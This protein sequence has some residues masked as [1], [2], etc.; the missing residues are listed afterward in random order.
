[1]YSDKKGVTTLVETLVQKGLRHVVLSPGSRNAPLSLSFYHHPDM[2]CLVIPDE[3]SAAYFAL[4]MAQ[5]YRKPVA[6]VC[7]SGTAALNYAPAIAEAYYQKIPLLI[8]TA[9][10]PVAWIDQ[11]DGQTI[12]QRDVFMNYCKNNF[13]VSGDG[14][15]QED[16]WFTRRI[17][18]R[19]Y[20]E[21]MVNGIGP[22]HI[23]IPLSEP[24]YN[25]SEKLP[26]I[27]A[28]NTILPHSRM[29]ENDLQQLAERWNSSSKKII[30]SG[31]HFPD[32]KLNEILKQ[33]SYD[34]SLAILTETTS[35][36]QHENFIPC[37]DRVITSIDETE[38]KI[39]Q[40][41]I[42]VTFG[43]PV[44]SKKIKVFIR[45]NPPKEHWHIDLNELHLDTYQ[46]LT[47]TI[48]LEVV[49]FFEQ[50]LP[51]V[52]GVESNFAQQWKDRDEQTKKLHQEFL[53]NCSFSD[54]LVFD[55]ILKH[56]PG[57]SNL[58]LANSSP[59]RYVQ[60][61]NAFTILSYNSNRGASGIDGCTSTAAGA[62]HFSGK[63]TT[64]I[65]GDIGFFYDSNALWNNYLSKKLRIIIINNGGGG[66]FRI[67]E[68][69][70]NK[71]EIETLLETRQNLSAEF[72][73]KA[74]D[75]SYFRATNEIEL[76]RALKLFYSKGLDHCAVLEIFT[77]TEENPVILKNY[78]KYI[79][80]K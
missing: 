79:S 53:N 75:I 8:L 1:M 45:K 54:L 50:F 26:A 62:A 44:I 30:L 39:F 66:I 57:G 70:E 61:F 58:H 36:I 73:C 37:I 55:E 16:L 22:I 14:D 12:R 38:G 46:C 20:D 56:I 32:K 40:P 9:D 6:I 18:S 34:S 65:S 33:L 19:A 69:P 51:Q 60:L 67:I 76:N 5:Q 17:V 80:N 41:E 47:H 43:G 21:T 23:N 11:A 13:E 71:D 77:P 48:P 68:G 15:S 25:R 63:E 27:K 2:E 64:L 28:I 7:T 3:R 29:A 49:D 59:V 72:L 42:L 24:L 52:K 78:F 35:N 31:L 74:Y 4:G 10:R